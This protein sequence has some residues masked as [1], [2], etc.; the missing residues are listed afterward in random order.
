MVESLFEDP[1]VEFSLPMPAE[2]IQWALDVIG[3]SHGELARRLEVEPSK[4]S[5]WA[6]GKSYMP[7]RVAIWLEMLAGV[8]QVMPKPILW[9]EDVL[10]SQATL[11]ENCY[12][13]PP[14]RVVRVARR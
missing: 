3:W 12:G 6:G 13:A 1:P 2:R 9:G 5:K 10:P 4:V 8:M 7:N 14:A 11:G